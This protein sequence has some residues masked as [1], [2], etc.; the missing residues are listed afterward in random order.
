MGEEFGF[1]F[2]EAKPDQ[3]VKKRRQ[4]KKME[5]MISLMFEDCG[6]LDLMVEERR[7]AFLQFWVCDDDV[8]SSFGFQGKRQVESIYLF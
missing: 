2:D 5:K 6:V 8:G 7:K 1:G 4:R 3:I